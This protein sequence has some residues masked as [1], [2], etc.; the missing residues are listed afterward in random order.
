VDEEIV[1]LLHEAM[2]GPNVLPE[3][4]PLVTLTRS[5]AVDSP[6]SSPNGTP[7]ESPSRIASVPDDEPMTPC[8]TA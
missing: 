8:R 7:A 6:P 1:R 3:F 5:E 2:Y 4:S